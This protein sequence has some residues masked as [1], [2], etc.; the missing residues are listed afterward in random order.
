IVE[1]LINSLGVQSQAE[2]IGLF[3]NSN[4]GKFL[5]SFVFAIIIITTLE[6][7]PSILGVRPVAEDNFALVFTFCRSFFTPAATNKAMIQ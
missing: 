2:K 5:G 7:R 6:I 4:V 3:K 1:G